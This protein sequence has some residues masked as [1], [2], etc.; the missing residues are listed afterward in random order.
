ML[1]R[2]NPLAEL[3][4]RSTEMELGGKLWEFTQLSFTL[5]EVQ[6]ALEKE[7]ESPSDSAHFSALVQKLHQAQLTKVTESGSGQ[8]FEGDVVYEMWS[9]EVERIDDELAKKVSEFIDGPGIQQY[10]ELSEN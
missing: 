3:L 10:L 8:T 6:Q 7:V 4:S 2:K 1:K 5:E 9:T